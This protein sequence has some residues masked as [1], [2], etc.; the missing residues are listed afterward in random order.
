MPHAGSRVY[1]NGALFIFILA[2]KSVQFLD[3][4]GN[5][6]LDILTIFTAAGV[7]LLRS[8]FTPY[9]N[10][11]TNCTNVCYDRKYQS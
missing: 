8:N 3:W 9:N 2:H 1:G 4:L 10:Y 7:K 5:W 6:N 11:Y